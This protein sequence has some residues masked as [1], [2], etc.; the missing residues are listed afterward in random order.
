MNNKSLK[1]LFLCILGAFSILNANA[2]LQTSY[3]YQ[4]GV[5]KVSGT[6]AEFYLNG[7]KYSALMMQ[8]S[9]G[10]R[11]VILNKGNAPDSGVFYVFDKV[12]VKAPK[13]MPLQEINAALVALKIPVQLPLTVAG[14]LNFSNY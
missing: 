3:F 14:N 2:N 6:T 4:A 5:N 11:N 7:V 8:N 13:Q 1:V 9:D 12:T 10:Y